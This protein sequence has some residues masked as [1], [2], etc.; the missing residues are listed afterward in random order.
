MLSFVA[1]LTARN[2][3]LALF[4]AVIFVVPIVLMLV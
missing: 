2:R 3:N 1:W 4:M